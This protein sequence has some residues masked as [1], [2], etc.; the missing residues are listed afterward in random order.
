VASTPSRVFRVGLTGGIASGKT[1][2]AR[3]FEALG[4]PI[5]DTDVLARQLVAPG[6]VLLEHI[7]ATFGSGVIA[8]DGQ[9]D[10]RT[11]RNLVFSD[12]AARAQLESLMHPA[13]RAAVEARCASAA[14]P[15]QVLVI[16][17]LVEAGARG[18]AIDRVL[19]VDCDEQLQ[20]RRLQAR[21]GSTAEQVRAIFAA[22]ATRD[23]RLQA[24]DDVIS[25]NGDLNALR[26]QV[27]RLHAR[28]LEAAKAR[29]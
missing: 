16:P 20:M 23:A 25:N 15:Y 17:L 27:E 4:V 1:T 8:P 7:A 19:V 24:A 13:I 3:L 2:V 26:T 9:L 18:Y 14:G 21:D 28:Y 22:Q 6:T 29:P 10:R 5:I 12:P 11:M